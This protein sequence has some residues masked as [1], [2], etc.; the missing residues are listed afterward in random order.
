M[1]PLIDEALKDLEQ[2][3]RD[4]KVNN[5]IPLSVS[6][7]SQCWEIELEAGKKLFGKT[8]EGNSI[9]MLEFEWN[10][11]LALRNYM[12]SKFIDIPKPL[13]FKKNIYGAALL[14]PWF[15]F[16]NGCQSLLG[17]GLAELHKA[18]AE[19]SPDCFGWEEE[20]FIGAGEQKGGWETSWG[21]YFVKLRLLPQ[22]Q[23]A[24]KKWRLEVPNQES[25][26]SALICYLSNHNPSPSLVHGDLW[27][28]NAFV[29]KDG[30]G[31]ILDPAT[32]WADREVDLA[33]TKL[34]GGFS[35]DFYQSYQKTWPTQSSAKEREEIY[36][37]YHLLNHAN[38]FGGG[39]KNQ[40]IK[41]II[42]I[43]G[44]LKS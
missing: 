8:G 6:S 30:R 24:Q 42:N 2:P 23:I 38:L 11:L 5:I 27:S 40:C 29:K 15:E 7:S 31:L 26:L 36:N 20:G 39:Y 13:A 14:M 1:N 44:F 37:L 33:M 32:Y 3:L 10:G 16:G 22:M 25:L 12:N 17:K 28:G 4:R 43:W 19:Q 41:S 34:F 21:E 35:K 9:Q 18:S